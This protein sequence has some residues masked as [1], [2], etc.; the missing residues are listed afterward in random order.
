M[1]ALIKFLDSQI[2]RSD[3]RMVTNLSA[4]ITVPQV[5]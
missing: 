2:A 5:L 1:G 3:R 4:R